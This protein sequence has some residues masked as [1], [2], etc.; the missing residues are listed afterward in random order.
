MKPDLSLVGIGLYTPAEAGRLTGI[1]SNKIIRWLRGHTIGDREYER[2]WAP[3]IDLGDSSVYL[4]FLDLVQVRVAAAFIAAGL[5]PQKVRKAID[6]G[7][8]V[9]QRDYP[10]ANARFRTDGQTVILHVLQ[11]GEDDRL[12]DLFRSGQYVMQRVI[13]PSLKGLEFENDFAARW[14]PLG[15]QRGIVIDPKRQ[16]G[17]PIDDTSGVPTVVLA[18]AAEAEGSITKAARAFMVPRAS[19]RRAVA[20]EERRAA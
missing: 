15:R 16:F 4:G 11:E 7:R 19:V 8:E 17:Q 9:I 10:F 2:L 14:W 13:E 6:Y 12:I 20:F 1:S 5:S 18:N 3:Q